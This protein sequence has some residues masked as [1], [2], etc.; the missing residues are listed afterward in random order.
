MA[1]AVKNTPE[2]GS[3]SLLDRMAVASLAGTAYALGT[4]GI[5]FYL[6][7]SLWPADNA[8]GITLR[9]LVQLVV[10]GGLIVFGVRMLGP[11][12]AVGVRAGIFVGLVGVLLIVLLTRWA[13]LWI[14]Y[15]S[16]QRGLFGPSV[17]AVLTAI[18]GL[19]LLAL[20]VRFFL[21][22]GSEKFL[23]RLE[24]QGWFSAK[25]YK[26]L[27]GV[28]VRRGTIFGILLLVGAGIWTMLAHNTLRRG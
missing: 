1:V 20:G 2:V 23:R 3:A 28:R 26:P 10:L 21:R 17:G 9:G 19:A 13:S 16:F 14:E 12:T 6:L 8:A 15:F 27:Q 22:P 11:K 7:P 4:L 5:A 24:E 18:V 25:P